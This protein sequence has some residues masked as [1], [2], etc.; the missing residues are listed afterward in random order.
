MQRNIWLES[1]FF[2]FVCPPP[3]PV[4]IG[5]NRCMLK[6][7]SDLPNFYLLISCNIGIWD[8]LPTQKYSDIFYGW[9]PR[10]SSQQ[11]TTVWSL[12]HHTIKPIFFAKV[13]VLYLDRLKEGTW[14]HS[15]DLTELKSF[16]KFVAFLF[17]WICVHE[18]FFE[19]DN[20]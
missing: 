7:W 11:F 3:P 6:F 8:P 10:Y 15:F 17:S 14:L 2:A 18:I 9:P 16:L 20:Y 5:W 4:Q 13:R 19:F 1:A 12:V